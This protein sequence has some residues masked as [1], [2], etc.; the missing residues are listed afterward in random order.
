MILEQLMYK[1]LYNFLTE[2][3]IIYELQFGFRQ[4]F[5]TKQALIGRI[6]W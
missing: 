6:Y 4:N 3:K 2:S 1:G 5:P